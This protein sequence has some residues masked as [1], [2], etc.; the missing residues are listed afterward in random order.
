MAVYD[1]SERDVGGSTFSLP[2]LDA[3]DDLPLPELA[4]GSRIESSEEPDLRDD[5][6]ELR[7]GVKGSVSDEESEVASEVAD[8]APV[9]EDASVDD[10]PEFSEPGSIYDEVVE[11]PDYLNLP[12]EDEEEAPESDD[13]ADSEALK[14]MFRAQE[15]S[16]GELPDSF[17]VTKE[18]TPA[19]LFNLDQVIA[20]AI[21]EGASDI[22]ISPDDYTAFSIL[23]AIERKP[24]YGMLTGFITEGLQ[25]N[26]LTHVLEANFVERLELD[27]S[28][29]LSET[30]HAGRRCRLSVGK[31]F[32][33]IFMVFRVISD[34]IPSPEDLGVSEELREWS[35]LPNGL[36]MMN[37]PTGTGKA[38]ALSTLIPTPDGVRELREINEGD[39]VFDSKHNAV[40]VTGLSPIDDS[41]DLYRV[42]LSDGQVILADANHQWIVST[43]S[44][45]DVVRNK[46]YIELRAKKDAML[47][48]AES[49]D[50][51]NLNAANARVQEIHEFIARF[52]AHKAFPRVDSLQRVFRFM[53]TPYVGTR[54]SGKLYD[55]AQALS[56]LATRIRQRYEYD[57]VSPLRVLTTSEMI[58][59]GI[60]TSS[61]GSNFGIPVASDEGLSRE[62]DLPIDPYLFGY[63]LGDG[64]TSSNTIAVGYEDLEETLANLQVCWDSEIR[65]DRMPGAARLTLVTE[66]KPFRTI[67]REIDAF[68][69]KRIP[70]IYLQSSREQRLELLRGIMDSDG[71]ASSRD[72]AAGVG[73][74]SKILAEDA[75]RLVRSLGITATL[76]Y[77]DTYYRLPDGTRKKCKGAYYFNFTSSEEVF[78][79]S[80]KQTNFA[81]SERRSSSDWIYVKSVERVD[82]DADDYESV[83]C[84]SVDSED[85]SYLC[86]DHIV[87]HNSTTL[88]SLLNSAI[89]ERAQKI[90]TIERPIEYVFGRDGKGFVTQR[91]VG[92]DS[93]EFS[94]ALD[95]AMRQA[96]D[97]IMI[98]ESRNRVEIDQVL[99]AAETGHLTFTTMHTNSAAATIN[100]I[101]S[102]FEGSEQARV[103]ST[104]SDVARGFANQV[105]VPTVDGSSR[106]AIREVLPF[107]E[108]VSALVAE[109]DVKGIR[110]FQIENHIT[111]EDGLVKAV[112]DGRCTLEAAK[113]QSAY[114]HMFDQMI[115]DLG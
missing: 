31:T 60:E 86:A 77:K 25:Q 98:G 23:G 95:S 17:E 28:Y 20:D 12:P 83:R 113:S 15:A 56:D 67:L 73:F 14:A 112:V 89:Q 106:F 33:D 114:P 104:L 41:P 55:T 22:H 68:E 53:D 97:I 46:G 54:Y 82:P 111:M 48:I 29:V 102:L 16:G 58:D 93:R 1:D 42:V 43:H 85:H 49:L 75:L 18:P 24:Q 51:A 57:E 50:S 108:E 70:N 63:W 72:R 91:E 79:L 32:G 39:Y 61:S 80:R 34:N 3:L 59:E 76:L 94:T 19:D 26:I 37:G 74:A 71:S 101:K 109:A 62:V 30:H 21:D 5:F 96:P 84:I 92:P 4:E 78:K 47:A 44:S 40:R 115:K 36:I 8:F 87:T 64:S 90:I 110:D 10:E 35:R 99:R 27:T 103:L 45:R 66:T 2:A 105:L 7:A 100:R 13:L 9:S 65:V 88:A 52:D 81:R 38:L 69:M 107:T 11:H 6:S